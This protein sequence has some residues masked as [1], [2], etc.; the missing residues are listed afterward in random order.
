MDKITH[1][2][3]KTVKFEDTKTIEHKT[4]KDSKSGTKVIDGG[5]TII[6]INPPKQDKDKRGKIPPWLKHS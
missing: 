3:T 1:K 2:K 5:T 6:N 4:A